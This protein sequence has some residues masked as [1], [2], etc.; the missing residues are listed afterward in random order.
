[1]MT[2]QSKRSCRSVRDWRTF[3]CCSL[4]NF[5]FLLGTRSFPDHFA[6]LQL[7]SPEYQIFCFTN[8][9]PRRQVSVQRDDPGEYATASRNL[10]RMLAKRPR[11]Y[12]K[13]KKKSE[14]NK[15]SDGLNLHKTVRR[16]L[17]VC[18]WSRSEAADDVICLISREPKVKNHLKE[19]QNAFGQQNPCK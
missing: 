3:I 12:V 17:E 6:V 4:I 1:M 10:A 14:A 18:D 16:H 15:K 13:T 9:E 11:N 2:C 8:G 7:D 5:T 19:K